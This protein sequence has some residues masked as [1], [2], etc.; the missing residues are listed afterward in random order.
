M[1]NIMDCDSFI[2]PSS[3]S[4]KQEGLETFLIG[5]CKYILPWMGQH[6]SP[7]VISAHIPPL[8]TFILFK[9]NTASPYPNVSLIQILS[10][11]VDMPAPAQL[12]FTELHISILLALRKTYKL[13]PL[14]LRADSYPISCSSS[15]YSKGSQRKKTHMFICRNLNRCLL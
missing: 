14:A 6:R 12:E 9:F 13:S 5:V 7:A 10:F 3:A 15:V 11:F 8:F 1:Y 2:Y 4:A